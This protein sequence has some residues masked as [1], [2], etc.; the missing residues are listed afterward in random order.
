MEITDKLNTLA[1][2]AEYVK[3]HSDI[4]KLNSEFLDLAECCFKELK[5]ARAPLLKLSD[6]NKPG[7]TEKRKLILPDMK[8]VLINKVPKIY[9]R[10]PL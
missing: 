7:R 1:E 6:H 5:R 2:E 3:E 8:I 10:Y 9:S 4:L